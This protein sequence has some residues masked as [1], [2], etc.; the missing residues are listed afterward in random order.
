MAPSKTFQL[1]VITPERVTLSCPAWFVAFPAFDGEMGILAHHAPLL[2]KLGAGALR[3]QSPDGTQALFVDGGF[4][5]MVGEKLTILTA[6]ATAIAA[7][8]AAEAQ[9]ELAAALAQPVRDDAS[10]ARRQHAADRARAELRLA[11][12]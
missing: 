7:L 5:Q 3:V 10:Y 6:G 1:D 4:A 12:H 11:E 9:R 2:A 8:D